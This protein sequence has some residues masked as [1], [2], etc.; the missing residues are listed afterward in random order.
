M[1]DLI[2]HK[3]GWGDE[4]LSIPARLAVERAYY[5]IAVEDNP[6]AYKIRPV[7]QISPIM[8]KKW[9][10]FQ[11]SKGRQRGSNDLTLLTDFV[12][13]KPYIF[14]PQDTG[15]CVWSNT[16]RGIVDRM[17]WEIMIKG[18]PEEWFGNQEFG[19]NS[20]APHMISYGFARQ[21]ANMKGSDGLYCQPMIESMMKDGFVT[22]NTPKLIEVMNAAGAT[23]PEDFPEPR[24]TSLIRKL[25]NW[26]FNDVLR[27]YGDHRLLES[28]RI[29]SA[30][31]LLQAADESKPAMMCSGIA[32]K[33]KG[34]SPDGFT[35]HV[36]NPNDSWAHNM[37]WGGKRVDKNGNVY[38]VLSNRSWVQANATT[39]E[40]YVYNIPIE[41]AEKWIGSGNVDCMTLGEID[42]P[43]SAPA[44]T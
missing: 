35:I 16:F 5:D 25:Q 18:D 17:L 43:D 24:S 19:I 27:P 13:G 11:E 9:E 28:V 29:K 31:D 6:V 22:C 40:A 21:R 23:Q 41:E 1:S 44:N 34:K 8:L 20:I 36:R 30:D 3:F 15:S 33:S 37:C 42:L 7:K 2:P 10:D 38:V 32:I 39:P 4:T 12:F 14:F 26:A